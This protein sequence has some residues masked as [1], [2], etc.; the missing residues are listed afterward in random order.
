MILALAPFAFI[1]LCAVPWLLVLSKPLGALLAGLSTLAVGATLVLLT[2]LVT[3]FLQADPTTAVVVVTG[4][5]G[6]V[7][8]IF[9]LRDR[10]VL[11]R[12][13]RFTLARWLPASI[14]SLAWL[15]TLA[16][17][18]VI[19]GSSALTW[20][21]NGDSSNNIHLARALLA[22]HGLTSGAGNGVPLTDIL[23]AIAMSP[24]RDQKTQS[25]LLEH[26]LTALSTFWALAI[27]VSALLLGLVVASLVD[28]RR[29]VIVAIAA[30]SGSL[31]ALTFFVAGL[32]ID[33]GYLN[34]HVA[35]PLTLATWLTYLQTRRAPVLSAALLFGYGFLLLSV[36]TPLIVI[37]ASLIALLGFRSWSRLRQAKPKTTIAVGA[38][39]ALM[40]AYLVLVSLPSL[41][42]SGDALTTAGHGFPFTGWILLVALAIAIVSAVIVRRGYEGPLLEGLVVTSIAAIAG[43][44]FLVYTTFAASEPWLGYYPTKFLWQLTML[45]CSIAVSLLFRLVSTQVEAVRPR[46]V[47]AVALGAAVLLVASLGPAP[48]RQHFVVEQPLVRILAGHTWKTGDDSVRTVLA[49]QK[50][51]RPVVLWN[52]GNADEPF[53]NFWL[54]DYSGA[55]PSGDVD[56]RIFSVTGYRDFRDTGSYTVPRLFVLCAVVAGI[57]G[58]ALVYSQD[59]NLQSDLASECPAA[60]VTVTPLPP[61][62]P[63]NSSR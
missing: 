21:M 36:W 3:P 12:P 28:A 59:T 29:P 60:N 53:I 61:L 1:A 48:T 42:I 44:G 55:A 51:D 56:A 2:F 19:P 27:A 5:A 15:V 4:A 24:G 17:A 46:A 30:A 50:Q 18:R 32:P 37:P 57:G 47:V 52:S 63:G 58:T 11:R 54:L 13:T 6:V 35:L 45:F 62:A 34:V 14:G 43:Y 23:L 16:I 33:S 31:L 38:A 7:G 26:D 41:Q 22:Q 25:A 39:A 9:V 49:A 40:I 10:S 8:L 20:S